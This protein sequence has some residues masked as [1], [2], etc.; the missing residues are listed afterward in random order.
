MNELGD[1]L[2]VAAPVLVL[3]GMVLAGGFWVTRRDK[4]HKH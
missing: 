4:K 3:A 1:M 2:S